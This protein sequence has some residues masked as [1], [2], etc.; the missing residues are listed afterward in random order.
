MHEVDRDRIGV[1]L[2]FFEKPFVNL[3]NRRI[4][5]RI[6]RFCRSTKLVDM[7]A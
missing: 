5:M 3:V 7:W 2:A 1:V 6:V 4:D